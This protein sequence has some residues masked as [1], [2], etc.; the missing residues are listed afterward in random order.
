[1]TLIP[2]YH[3]SQSLGCN[4]TTPHASHR[5][6]VSKILACTPDFFST[7]VEVAAVGSLAVQDDTANHKEHVPFFS[8]YSYM[9]FR[10]K[11]LCAT[12]QYLAVDVCVRPVNIYFAMEAR[13][14]QNS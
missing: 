12:N 3:L 9:L 14:Q 6:M 1:M 10:N 8:G 11:W 13:E 5:Y 4:I 2:F 7:T